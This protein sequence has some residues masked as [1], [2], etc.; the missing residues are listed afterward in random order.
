[1]IDPPNKFSISFQPTNH[2]SSSIQIAILQ[3]SQLL[4]TFQSSDENDD[5]SGDCETI[6]DN[7]KLTKVLETCQDIPMLI[8]WVLNALDKKF[9]EHDN[10][11][12]MEVEE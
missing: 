11:V 10:T 7:K 8:E 1:V 2:K 5:I 9:G 12:K 3:D 6:L 4:V